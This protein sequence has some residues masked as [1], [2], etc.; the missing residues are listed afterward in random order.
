MPVFGSGASTTGWSSTEPAAT[1]V[2]S[3]HSGA[4]GSKLLHVRAEKQ[5][6]GFPAQNIEFD[7]SLTAKGISIRREFRG[8]PIERII[9]FDTGISLV[10]ESKSGFEKFRGPAQEDGEMIFGSLQ[11]FSEYNDSGF[12]RYRDTLPHGLSFSS[13]LKEARPLF[14]QAMF[15]HESGPN[16]MYLWYNFQQAG[17]TFA[18]C[19]LPR[20]KGISFLS[21]EKAELRPPRTR[22][23]DFSTRI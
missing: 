10:F 11:V 16:H 1:S 12:S 18:I 8:S 6:L 9:Q 21:L 17:W 14:G 3:E 19:F 13:A 15:D 23:M 20:E 4:L 5:Y 22:K 7:K 2:T